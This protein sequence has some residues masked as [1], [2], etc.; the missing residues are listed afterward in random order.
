MASES[1]VEGKVGHSVD[2]GT[3]IG[4]NSEDGDGIFRDIWKFIGRW[5]HTTP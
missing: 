4:V 2:V 1:K 5:G 3:A